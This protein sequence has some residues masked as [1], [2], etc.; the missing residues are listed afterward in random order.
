MVRRE[1]EEEQERFT[2]RSYQSH[3]SVPIYGLSASVVSQAYTV[4]SFVSNESWFASESRFTPRGAELFG[5]WPTC[6]SG[7]FWLPG[8]YCL[9]TLT[10]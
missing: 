10:T 9:I 1:R 3:V 7:K 4:L 6:L 2:E 5:L 8:G